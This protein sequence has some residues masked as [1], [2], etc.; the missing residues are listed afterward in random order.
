MGEIEYFN[1]GKVIVT[2][3]QIISNGHTYSLSK[4]ASVSMGVIKKRHDGMC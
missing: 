1:D 4:V 3:I 2:S